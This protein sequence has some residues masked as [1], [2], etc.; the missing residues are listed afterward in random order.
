MGYKQQ[1]LVKI[2]FTV[3]YSRNKLHQPLW[4]DPAA[5][6]WMNHASF[7]PKIPIYHASCTNICYFLLIWKGVNIFDLISDNRRRETIYFF[8]LIRHSPEPPS[9]FLFH[10]RWRATS[11][12]QRLV[13]LTWPNKTLVLWWVY[14]SQILQ[15][16][17]VMSVVVGPSC[18]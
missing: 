3:F 14:D 8:R 4:K 11:L 2:N 18:R 7:K 5:V 10:S 12:V 6:T 9:P 16:C 13:S 1:Q 15:L 17:T